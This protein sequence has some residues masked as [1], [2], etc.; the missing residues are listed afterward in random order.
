MLAWVTVETELMEPREAKRLY[1]PLDVEAGS[2]S[3]HSLEAAFAHA[4]FVVSRTEMLG[5]ELMEF[6]E[7]R[8]G[9]ASRELMRLTRMRRLRESL[10]AQWGS[11]KYDSAY[12]LYQWAIYLLLGKLNSGFYL[13]AKTATP[14]ADV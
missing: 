11:V 2:M 1:T 9:R 4:G 14:K 12:A 5:S 6:Y 8:D 10:R 3:K 13:L 7:E